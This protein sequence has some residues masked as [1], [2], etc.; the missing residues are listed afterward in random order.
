MRP[1]WPQFRSLRTPK[2]AK[3]PMLP[4]KESS[5]ETK[6]IS[7]E[8]GP[9]VLPKPVPAPR[10]VIGFNFNKPSAKHTY[11]NVPIPITPNT[12]SQP[13]VVK[14]SLKNKVCFAISCLNRLPIV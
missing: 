8:D 1:N 3:I 9:K 5:P 7:E 10:K 2:K 4:I 11:Q 14:E 13:Q 12:V 6:T